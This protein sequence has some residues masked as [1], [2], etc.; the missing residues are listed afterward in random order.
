MY[1]LGMPGQT[2]TCASYGISTV[3]L[4]LSIYLEDV[5]DTAW[6]KSS[7][8]VISVWHVHLAKE[9]SKNKQK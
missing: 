9:C 7:L 6:R 8:L 2:E 4:I 5:L 1:S 3:T